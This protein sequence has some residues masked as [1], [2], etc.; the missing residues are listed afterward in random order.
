MIRRSLPLLL[1]CAIA[2]PATADE[3]TCFGSVAKGR[4]EGGVE[5]PGE[6]KNFTPYSALGHAMGRT[7]VHSR[8][9]SVVLAAYQALERSA[10]GKGFVYGETGW[11]AGGRIKPHKTH[12]NGLSVD[13]MVPVTDASGAS[14]PLPTNAHNLFGYG[15]EFDG[16][17]KYGGYTIDFALIAEHLYQLNVAA[18]AQGVGIARVIFDRPYL[19]RLFATQRGN[20]VQSNIPFFKGKPWIRH[21]EHYHV[22]FSVPCQPL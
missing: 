18:H 22:D 10:P 15:I 14:V 12:Q 5:L 16:N 17:A 20:Y 7:Y 11:R 1:A 6:G 8:V 2:C 13:F 9:R 4:L 19:P 21:D 3:S